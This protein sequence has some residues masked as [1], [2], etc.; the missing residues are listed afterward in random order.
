MGEKY[1]DSVGE[2]ESVEKE[3]VDVKGKA[4]KVADSV[5]KGGGSK[6]SIMGT[7]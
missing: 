6:H 1:D 2:N 3:K 7:T 4:K 5:I